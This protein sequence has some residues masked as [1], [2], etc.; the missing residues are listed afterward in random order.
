MRQLKTCCEVELRKTNKWLAVYDQEGDQW[1]C[2]A[3][4]KCWAYADDEDEG[5]GWFIYSIPSV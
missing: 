1:T 4:Q 2:P 5:G 3:C